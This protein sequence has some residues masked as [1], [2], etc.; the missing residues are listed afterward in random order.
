MLDQKVYTDSAVAETLNSK[1]VPFKVNAEK[2]E[3]PDLQK[4]FE[5]RGFPTVV[6]VDPKTE[7]ELDRIVG[8]SP[9][10]QYL[11]KV[12]SILS[13][14]TFAGL[15][16]KARA[17]PDD[18][19]AWCDYA[20][21]LEERGEGDELK[22]AWK[23]VAALD[24]GDRKGKESLAICALARMD[25]F[26]SRDPRP[27]LE[28]ARKYEGKPAA[29]EAHRYLVMVLGRSQKKED[30]KTLL[31]SYEYL[32]SHGKRD[33]ETLNNYA[34]DLATHGESLEKALELAREALKESPKAAHIL[35]TAAECL[36][37]LGRKEE[38]VAMEKK[39][40]EAAAPAQK[41]SFKKRIAE[42]GGTA[43]RRF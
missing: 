35:D 5:V 4:K 15:R 6:F 19:E 33:A 27:L 3:G 12:R 9:P 14:K 23:K 21:A 30:R 42:F 40:L 41:E 31:E 34:W 43:E 13:G 11:K 22:E 20:E 28:V 38:A 25:A 10:E 32:I 7:E 2:G 39:A 16:K 1:A 36:F 29:V 26:K 24:P 17:N 8:Y 37:R 18:L